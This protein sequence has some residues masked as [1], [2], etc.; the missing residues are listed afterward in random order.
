MPELKKI[1][2][3][4]LETER[5]LLKKPTIADI[6]DVLRIMQK[7]EVN[8]FTG[9]KPVTYESVCKS[10]A[11]QMDE[12]TQPA[13]NLIWYVRLKS[14]NTLIGW[15]NIFG[16]LSTNPH[17]FYA[18][19]VFDSSYWGKGFAFE[20]MQKV[21]DFGFQSNLEISSYRF[22]IFNENAR[23]KKLAENLGATFCGTIP[24]AWNVEGKVFD[25]CVY[26][27]RR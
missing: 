24:E 19:Y 14:D 8:Q 18:G 11:D 10:I 15:V 5:L 27:L 17:Q 13:R 2:F 3:E 16:T 4:E 21:L 25:E 20:A 26:V 22:C 23:S 7:S 12:Y 6:S 9:I 1:S